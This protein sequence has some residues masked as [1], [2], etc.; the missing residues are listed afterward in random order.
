MP[1]GG[2]LTSVVVPAYCR[3]RDGRVFRLLRASHVAADTVR[4]SLRAVPLRLDD[5]PARI[6]ERSR[7]V[8][9]GYVRDKIRNHQAVPSPEATFEEL[10][11]QMRLELDAE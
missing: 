8:E 2:T 1:A 3:S 4:Y 11:Q 9:A 5:Q 10:W 7:E 6:I